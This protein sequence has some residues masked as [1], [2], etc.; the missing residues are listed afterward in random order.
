MKIN[1]K[2]EKSIVYEQDI[3]VD[4]N[5]PSFNY[6]GDW[7]SLIKDEQQQLIQEKISLIEENIVS[8]Y[9]SVTTDIIK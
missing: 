6:L 9:I 7:N 2:V 1:F 5:D 8:K 3:Q 4:V